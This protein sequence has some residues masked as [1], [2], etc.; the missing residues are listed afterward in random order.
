[1]AVMAT[2]LSLASQAA[3]QDGVG[4]PPS[5]SPYRDL[6]YGHTITAV[7]GYLDGGGGKLGLGPHDAW[8]FGAK[9][10]LRST[11]FI[12]IGIEGTTGMATR[13]VIDPLDPDGEYLQGEADQRITILQAMLQLNLSANK[14]W[15]RLA[16]YA[17]LGVGAAFGGNVPQD[18]SGYKFGTKV[19]LTPYLGVRLMPRPR[20]G[21]RIE[22]RAP[23][24]KLTYPASLRD[25]EDPEAATVTASEWVVSGWYTV[26]FTFAL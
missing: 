11:K 1:M 5:K 9:Y 6:V 14:T 17:G 13:N 19:V 21:I 25:P 10:Q 3:A 12:A 24:W 7:A 16:P 4:V 22:A 26:G 8:T 2:L 15:N 18:S 23:F 20:F